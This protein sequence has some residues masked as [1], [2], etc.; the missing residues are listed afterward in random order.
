MPTPITTA[1]ISRPTTSSESSQYFTSLAL[2]VAEVEP[3]DCPD[4]AAELAADTDGGRTVWVDACP[5]ARVR[6]A[7]LAGHV[8]FLLFRSIPLPRR[9]RG[10][11]W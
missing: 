10:K 2:L 5:V 9:Q 4:L 1:A 3:T 7:F 8:S 11:Q 6:A